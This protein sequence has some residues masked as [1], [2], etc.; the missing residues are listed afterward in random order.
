[1]TERLIVQT[2]WEGAGTSQD[3]YISMLLN[4]FSGD[5]KDVT[6]QPVT[7]IPPDANVFSCEFICDL[8]TAEAIAAD[9]DYYIQSWVSE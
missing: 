6:V 1:M 5:L 9:P 7:N 3:P 8:A 4:N 2:R